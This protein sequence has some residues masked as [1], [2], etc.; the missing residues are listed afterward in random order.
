MFGHFYRFNVVTTDTRAKKLTSVKKRA[1]I[2]LL[3]E[4]YCPQKVVRL[5]QSV[6]ATL[7]YFYEET[8]LSIATG[9]LTSGRYVSHSSIKY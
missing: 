2:K 3:A 1:I 5:L 7:F 8:L 9:T 6:K 4:N